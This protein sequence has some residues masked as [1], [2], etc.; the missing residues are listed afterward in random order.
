MRNTAILI[1]TEVLRGY[2][3]KNQDEYL[4]SVSEILRMCAK[5]E[6][7]GYYAIHSLTDLER[8]IQNWPPDKRRS[9]LQSLCSLLAPASTDSNSIQAAIQE[10]GLDSALQAACAESANCDFL[11][12]TDLSAFRRSPVPAITP[13]EFI[14]IMT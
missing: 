12:T 11:V 4:Y 10:P 6:I 5:G 3:L 9:A 7:L 14:E 2:L 13:I 1:D 8:T